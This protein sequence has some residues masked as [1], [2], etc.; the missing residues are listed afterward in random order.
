MPSACI[1][2]LVS[3]DSSERDPISKA[4]NTGPNF[5]RLELKGL[6]VNL[7]S[8]KGIFKALSMLKI[9]K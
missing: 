7:N 1:T 5:L 3:A 8:D 2:T 9:P 6:I 4:K